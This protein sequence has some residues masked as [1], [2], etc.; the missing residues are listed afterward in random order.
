MTQTVEDGG[1]VKLWF[2]EAFRRQ[3]DSLY[4]LYG[5]PIWLVGSA[6]VKERPRDIDVRVILC[7]CEMQRRYGR[8]F[9]DICADGS[10]N[11]A[12]WQWRRA[13]D[14]I[15]QSRALHDWGGFPIDFQIQSAGE[16]APY[17]KLER[18]RLDSAPEWV[19][20]AVVKGRPPTP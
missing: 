14:N 20:A 7:A 5:S 2:A 12:L 9:P 6:L 8:H 13:V 4:G 11:F 17:E 1:P 16:A 18:V 3:A 19:D 10:N 15:K